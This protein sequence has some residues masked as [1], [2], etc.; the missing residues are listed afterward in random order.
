MRH[1]SPL[2][3]IRRKF[4]RIRVGNHFEHFRSTSRNSESDRQAPIVVCIVA[5]THDGC[6]LLATRNVVGTEIQALVQ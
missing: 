1:S 2:R 4:R 5:S 6:H 3:M